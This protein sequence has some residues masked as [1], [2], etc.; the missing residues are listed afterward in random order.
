MKVK[1]IALAVFVLAVVAVLQIVNPGEKLQNVAEQEAVTVENNQTII[2]TAS[3]IK[4]EIN[5]QTIDMYAYNNSIPGP[6]IKVKQNSTINVE[7]RNDLPEKTLLHAHG[8]RMDN[9]FDGT[10]LVQEPIKSGETFT[11]KLQFPDAGV[12]WYHPHVREDRQ[13]EM[14]LYGLFI[15]EPKDSNYWPKVDREVPLVLDDMYITSKGINFPEEAD[16]VLMGRYGN[17]FL[18]NG[19]ES[20]KFK[21]RQGE[22]VRFLVLNAANARPFRIAIP[23]AKIK[24][25]GGDSGSYSNEEFIEELVI[26]P[27]ERYVID[28][29]FEKSG[30]FS[31][32]NRSTSNPIEIAVIDVEKGEPYNGAFST[33]RE[34]EFTA[35]EIQEFVKSGET[36][37]KD[38]ALSVELRMMMNHSGGMEGMPCHRMPD[39]SMMGDCDNDEGIE[40]EDTMSMMNA[41]SNKNNVSWRIID[42]ETELENEEIK[43]NLK[44]GDRVKVK[45]FNDPN[46][47]HPMQHPI[48]FHG[49]RF[50][51]L[52][53]DGVPNKNMVWKDTVLV[54]SGKTVEILL[55]ITNPGEWMAHCHIAEHLEGGMMFEY[56]VM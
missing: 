54:P 34:N 4:K 15:V 40:W 48:H 13:Q 43:W 56:Q 22:V 36:I 32:Q 42:G 24:L 39:G 53:T 2:L 49:Q 46:S 16:R 25:V 47:D 7:L 21:A 33:L 35:R 55:D 44:V 11:Y 30:T 45:I 6:I 12:Y 5:G 14:G 52:S 31:L 10:A 19:Q 1:L 26:S 50:V 37:T 28:V 38:I 3:Q 18:I 8:I 9:E 20:A 17:V 41:S 29:L 27:S 51:V 23:G